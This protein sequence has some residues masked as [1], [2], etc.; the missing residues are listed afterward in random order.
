M[1]TKLT[2]FILCR[3]Q[4]SYKS[5]LLF[6]FAALLLFA[7]T[8]SAQPFILDPTFG[9][10]GMTVLPVLGDITSF[11]YD[12]SGN[13]IAIGAH[14]KTHCD[15]LIM[16]KTDANGILDETFG[17]NGILVLEFERLTRW[18]FKITDE[19]KILLVVSDNQAKMIQLNEDGSFDE[20]FGNNGKIIILANM[21]SVNTEDQN[22][23]L[24]CNDVPADPYYFCTLSKYNYNGERDKEFGNKIWGGQIILQ[25]VGD[26]YNI[27]PRDIKILRDQ[28]I[29]I[30]GYSRF[31]T[32]SAK[33]AFCKVDQTGDFVEDF[34]DNGVFTM[35]L[36]NGTSADEMLV[37]ILEDSNGNLVFTGYCT[38]HRFVLRV[39]PNGV[40]DST[41]GEN[42]LYFYK[43]TDPNNGGN[44]LLNED[45]YLVG[46]YDRVVRLNSNGTLNTNFNDSGIY[47]FENF[48][49]R[50][51]KFQ[52]DKKLVLGGSSEGNFALVR[53]NIPPAV[54]V[55]ENDHFPNTQIVFPNPTTD[56]LHFSKEVKFEIM[57]IQG[58]ILLQS[59]NPVQTV[60]V[61]HLKTG[62]YFI[63][64]EDNRIGKFMKQ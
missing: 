39:L 14:L 32:K 38:D 51:M 22:Y 61:N 36:T 34:A 28:S 44:I 13:I 37:S 40:I 17:T 60:H 26:N 54:S 43:I 59:E 52:E 63:R 46:W 27:Y 23:W 31:P 56:Y 15:S 19:N 49:F 1:K 57:D 62:L 42:G 10:N 53:L 3:L 35:D 7:G 6:C 18:D 33:I 4:S 48:T 20:S 29:L 55:K 24:L 8:L 47:N 11:N 16:I 2:L 25:L 9:E 5:F 58:K 12:A 45:K 30:A 21:I 50:N 64:F 41:F